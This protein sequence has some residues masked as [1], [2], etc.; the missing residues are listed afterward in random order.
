MKLVE[1]ASK[2]VK[3]RTPLVPEVGTEGGIVGAVPEVNNNRD[4][5]KYTKTA[6]TSRESTTQF[7]RGPLTVHLV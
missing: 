3:Q 4:K 6:V 5:K 7:H 1:V 2:G